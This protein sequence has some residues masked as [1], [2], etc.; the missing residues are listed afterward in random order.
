MTALPALGRCSPGAT[1]T[2][3]QGQ[4]ALCSSAWEAVLTTELFLCS[5]KCLGESLLAMYNH[6]TTCEPPRPS[7]GKRVDLSDY[8]DLSQHPVSSAVA[9]P[10]SVVQPS[11][12]S[13]SSSVTVAEPVLSCSPVATAS[14]PLHSPSLLESGVPLG[15]H[16]RGWLWVDLVCWAVWVSWKDTSCSSPGL[17]FKQEALDPRGV[18]ACSGGCSSGALFSRGRLRDTQ[19]M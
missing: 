15:E 16:P 9:A 2:L 7:L 5:W 8:Q 13:A 11:P 4:L 3:F 19:P 12:V 18:S 1:L 17:R 6:L 14:F 10:L